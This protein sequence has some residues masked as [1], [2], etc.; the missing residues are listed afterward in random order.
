MLAAY[1]HESL[2]R[3]MHVLTER[4]IHF[5][6]N[7]DANLDMGPGFVHSALEA[8]NLELLCDDADVSEIN[9]I[10]QKKEKLKMRKIWF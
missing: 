4:V 1:L 5:C 7:R 3:V 8:F 9:L 10:S 6:I 2:L